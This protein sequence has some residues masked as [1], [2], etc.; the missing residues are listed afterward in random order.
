[1]TNSDAARSNESQLKIVVLG[2]IVRG[3][4]GGLSWHHLQYI[5]GL[6]QLGHDVYFLEDSGDYEGSCY[7]PIQKINTSD[8]TNGLRYTQS[9]LNKI[10][11]SD[12]WAYYDA[13]VSKWFGPQAKN[14]LD[15]CSSAD[16]LLNVSGVNVIRPW[17]EQIP[18]RVFIDTDPVFTQIK[19]LTDADAKS[20]AL[21]HNSFFT[22]GENLPKSLFNFD[23]SI[24]WQAT[25]QPVVLN[26]WKVTT[27]KKQG[28]FTS[29][30]Q[31]DS[32][33]PREYAGQRYG[34]KADSFADYIDLPSVAGQVFNLAITGPK[35]PFSLLQNKGWIIS[36]PDKIA[37]TPWKYQ[38]F[39]EQSKAEF[40]VAK[41]GYV[42]SRCGWFSERSA[43]YLASGRPVV[44]QETGFSDWLP[45]GD[46]ILPFNNFDEAVAGIK[47]INCHYDF[48]C[49][50][51]R[52]I[53]EEYFDSKK[54]LSS[55]LE[56]ALD[57]Y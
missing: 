43:A 33:P 6:S 42:V 41:H 25:R 48:H 7:D 17:C 20:L 53:A 29:V 22:F 52:A 35:T 30:M 38:D 44:T 32:Y 11:F 47:E 19:H 51:A 4:L 56:R 37:Q 49:R 5:L 12:R 31:W 40:T 10:N 8:P 39:I 34:M 24:D 14:V 23:D 54:I 46:G 16:I 3:P 1:M 36:D 45:V 57:N 27:P 13:H 55:L 18:Y 26:Q 9:V 15:I 50:A 2:Y 21:K 28:K